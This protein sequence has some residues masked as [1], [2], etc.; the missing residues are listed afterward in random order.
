MTP[1]L[2]RAARALRAAPM[3]R[4]RANALATAVLGAGLAWLLLRFL[5]WAFVHAIWTV[6]SGASSALCRAAKGEGAC[7]AVIDDRSRF[8]LFGAYPYEEQW[9]PAVVCLLFV[10]LYALSAAR[11][12]WRPWLAGV[13]VAVP[14][15]SLTLLRGGTWGL[16]A[17]PSERW[18]G[19]PLTFLFATVGFAAAF[20]LAVVLAFGR[21]SS[22][23]AI[24]A[25]SVAYIELVR[26]VPLMT[27]LF[28]AAVLFPLFVPAGFALDKLL[29]A[30]L[31]L[32]LVIATHLAEVI[33]GGLQA[34]PQAQYEAAASMGLRFWPA[35]ILVV[36]PQALR[37]TIPAIVNTFIAFFKDTSLVAVIGLFDL[38]GAARAA[39]VDPRWVGFSLEVYLFVGG[40]YFAFCFAVSSYSQRLEHRLAAHRPH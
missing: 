29:R 28:M 22:M 25:L 37:V 26:G 21:R 14:A 18:G 1:A 3:F 20:P 35:M 30:Q 16:S 7:W 32:V 19:L 31:A 12:C 8:I 38:L 23:P 5:R 2:I 40:L 10:A 13:W 11:A 39:I 27:A 33:R 34:V 24:R 6:P 17:V 15:A 9:R 36:L 4:D